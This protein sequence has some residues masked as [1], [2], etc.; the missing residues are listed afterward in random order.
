MIRSIA[1]LFVSTLITTLS[2]AQ[3]QDFMPKGEQI[4]IEENLQTMSA[5][6][7]NALSM[8]IPNADEKKVEHVWKQFSK[9]FKTRTQRDRKSGLYV[10]DDAKLKNISNNTVDLYAQFERGGSGT[11]VTLWFDLGGAYLAS[12][13]HEAAY[14]SAQQMMQDFAKAVK[15]SMAEDDLKVQEKAL[16]ELGKELERLAKDKEQYEKKI[17]EANELIRE[18]ENSIK[19]NEKDQEAKQQQIDAQSKVVS[20][21]QDKVR[22]YN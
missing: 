6:T 20:T 22:Q 8:A 4:M 12:E 14:E 9:D 17:A 10:S 3:S 16:K 11:L 1:I 2:F 13:T 7:H 5:G 15:K 21:A 19:Q 18:M